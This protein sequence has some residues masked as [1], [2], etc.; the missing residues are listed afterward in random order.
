MSEKKSEFIEVST[1]SDSQY[2]GVFGNNVDRKISKTNLFSQIKDES[3]A[4]FIY[5]SIELLQA[6]DL[7]ADEDNPTY[8]RCEETEYRLYKITNLAAGVD[9]ITLDNGNTATYQVEYRYVIENIAAL[10]STP[11]VS[12]QVYYLKEGVLGSGTNGG[13]LLAYTGVDTP[14]NRFVFASGTAGV[15][16]KR[17]NSQFK[18]ASALVSYLTD[19]STTDYNWSPA[20]G[21]ATNVVASAD[22]SNSFIG[23]ALNDE[24]A[25]TAVFPAA[26]TG[27]GRNNGAGN[28]VFGL[29]GR[30]DQR[31]NSGVVTNEVNSFN[32]GAAPSSALPPDRSFGTAQQ[33]P[34][35]LTVAA[36]GDADSSI[37]IHIAQEG[38]EPQSFLT[39]LYIGSAAVVNYA[40]FVDAVAGSTFIP[41]V[42]KHGVGAAAIAVSGVGT[43]S[44]SSA[45]MTYTDG[46]GN[47][48]FAIK[49]A[50]NLFF[51]TSLTQ[52]TVGAPGA[53]AV[54]PSNP[55][56]Y[57]K[58]EINGA[59]KLVPYYEP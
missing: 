48:K 41:A 11:A 20:F 59:T 38:S 35:A 40:V 23:M 8:V 47:I 19:L 54:L 39:G 26:V 24:P 6:A 32:Y 21:V 9:D 7:E 13:E 33:H 45:W 50:G 30:A 3:F 52:S 14:D 17:I 51:A 15:L 4:P 1:V 58:I 46:S 37:G 27:Y 22:G 12:D 25:A 36:G 43:P 16:F 29:F 49:Q 42:I 5:P 10:A 53:A 55:T 31:A 56:G 2:F 18:T 28:Q 34:V 57:L 44:S